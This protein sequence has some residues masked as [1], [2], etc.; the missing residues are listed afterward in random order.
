MVAVGLLKA[1]EAQA[2][3]RVLMK[4]ILVLE[5]LLLLNYKKQ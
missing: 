3:E 1:V 2:Q 4:E 5:I